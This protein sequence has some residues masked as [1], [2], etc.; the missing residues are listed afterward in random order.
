MLLAYTVLFCFEF[1]LYNANLHEDFTGYKIFQL[2]SEWLFYILIT[3]F[4]IS[5]EVSHHIWI[6][7]LKSI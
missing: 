2:N 3:Q 1:S 6:T 7:I 5:F 4:V